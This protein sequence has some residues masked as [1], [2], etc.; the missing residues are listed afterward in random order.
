MLRRQRSKAKDVLFS[1]NGKLAHVCTGCG[2][3]RSE[4]RKQL[5]DRQLAD[6]FTGIYELKD[7]SILEAHEW[8]DPDWEE[9][10]VDPPLGSVYYDIY[11]NGEGVDGGVMGYDSGDTI[12]NLSDFVARSNS[13]GISRLIAAEGTPEYDEIYGALGIPKDYLPIKRKYGLSKNKKA[14]AVEPGQNL[15]PDGSPLECG[16]CGSNNCELCVIEP[17]GSWLCRCWSCGNVFYQY[18]EWF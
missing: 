1:E 16:D 15:G 8:D 13:D 3:C 17:T 4:N 6:G 7:G 5:F 11:E 10:G 9:C 12:G 2:R 18:P 14:V